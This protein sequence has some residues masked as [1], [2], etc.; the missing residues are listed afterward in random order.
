MKLCED[1]NIDPNK[2]DIDW[3][4]IASDVM[5]EIAE[6]DTIWDCEQEAYHRTIERYLKE[7][8]IK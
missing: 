5:D 8:G 6:N 4:Q 1:Y 3:K 7:R 2:D